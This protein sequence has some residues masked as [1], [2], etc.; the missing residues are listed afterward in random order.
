MELNENGKRKVM[1]ERNKMAVES[2][3]WVE[4]GTNDS[5]L[6]AEGFGPLISLAHPLMGSTK[7][8]LGPCG[9][10]DGE[11][12]KSSQANCGLN[13]LVGLDPPKQTAQAHFEAG[14]S[15]ISG[16]KGLKPSIQNDI[17]TPSSGRTELT[18]TKEF[19]SSMVSANKAEELAMSTKVQHSPTPFTQPP[20][21]PTGASEVAQA[22]HVPLSA[23][24]APSELR[25][26]PVV[27][28]ATIP[29]LG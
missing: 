21:V 5:V 9:F 26:V 23:I 7:N 6:V 1:W 2:S 29:K 8:I 3:S 22:S 24:S 17:F 15:S 18:A 28:S 25:L 20:S 4:N 10:V 12:S 11:C 14:K 19:A 27:S 16:I 13:T